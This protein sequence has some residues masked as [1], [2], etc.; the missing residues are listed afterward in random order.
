MDKSGFPFPTTFID[1]KFSMFAKLK[2]D[3]NDFKQVYVPGSKTI[4]RLERGFE[5]NDTSDSITDYYI[6]KIRFSCSFKGNK[7]PLEMYESFYTKDDIQISILKTLKTQKEKYEYLY[8]QGLKVCNQY[9]PYFAGTVYKYFNVTSIC[10]GSLGWF[11]R[12]MGA[13]CADNVKIFYGTDP[14]I[15]LK[16]CYDQLI[17]D[18]IPSS[19]KDFKLEYIPFEDVKTDNKYAMFMSSTPYYDL[20]LYLK[21]EDDI[22]KTQ[23]TTRYTTYNDWLKNFYKIYIENGLKMTTKYFCLYTSNYRDIKNKLIPLS[24]DTKYIMKQHADWKQ[25]PSIFLNGR[26]LLCWEKTCSVPLTISPPSSASL[27]P[28][29]STPSS[30]PSSIHLQ[31]PY[32]AIYDPSIY[33]KRFIFDKIFKAEPNV[34]T[35]IWS[36]PPGK[37]KSAN[38]DF[39]TF[40]KLSKIQCLP[41]GNEKEAWD[42]DVIADFYSEEARVKSIGYGETHSPFEFALSEKLRKERGI[43]HDMS[44]PYK[45]REEINEKIQEARLAY[46]TTSKSL[47]YAIVTNFLGKDVKPSILDIAAY[48][49][50]FFASAALGYDYSGID[51]NEYLTQG[52]VKL[53]SDMDSYL[54]TSETIKPKLNLFPL[55]S[56]E[57]F[58]N[59]KRYNIFSYSPPPFNLELYNATNEAQT[60]NMY[61][62]FENYILG[63]L[64]ESTIRA[65]HDFLSANGLF[66]F[67][68]LDRDPSKYKPKDSKAKDVEI[69]YVE[70]F[71]HLIVCLGFEYKSTISFSKSNVPWFIFKSVENP[72]QKTVHQ[73]L[74][75][76]EK[77]Y[78]FV[79]NSYRFRSFCAFKEIFFRKEIT[80]KDMIKIDSFD[81]KM[82]VKSIQTEILRHS[83]YNYI[84]LLLFESFEEKIPL[85][86]IRIYYSR[87]IAI[88]KS[89]GNLSFGDPVFPLLDL[90]V[91]K[92]VIN[93]ANR[94]FADNVIYANKN[95]KMD[96]IISVLNDTYYWFEANS[97]YRASQTQ[98]IA[99]L[100]NAASRF[101]S[102]FQTTTKQITADNVPSLTKQVS[103]DVETERY[104][105][106]FE[107]SGGHNF[108]RPI[109][110]SQILLKSTTFDEIIDLFAN[111]EN[112]NSISI[113]SKE[114]LPFFSLFED[115]KGSL[116][117]ALAISELVSGI[118][119]ANAID[120]EKITYATALKFQDLLKIAEKKGN[121]IFIIVGTNVWLDSED[122]KH[123]KSQNFDKI[124]DPT[125]NIYLNECK[126]YLIA[127]YDLD[128]TVFESTLNP[129]EKKGK[130]SKARAEI[131]SSFGIIL[132]TTNARKNK[133][134]K[135]YKSILKELGKLEFY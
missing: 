91:N 26:E 107:A 58:R 113:T 52:Y 106:L 68:A 57:N 9:N 46:I 2:K 133:L 41:A 73:S 122:Y 117:N 64:L 48:G 131:S 69:Y 32:R 111:F 27:A 112:T 43:K 126:K 59:S 86:K 30:T 50:R 67:T 89:L 33:K 49:E 79:Y 10:D 13:I 99:D 16:P 109:R 44:D 17:K 29:P 42:L 95:F 19:G 7:S 21:P 54:S 25:I 77:Y 116:G 22:N 14:N 76:L 114:K 97:F 65:K 93:I 4:L 45:F 80:Y 15:A 38:N 39:H 23:S 135:D 8:S 56:I 132:G 75:V 87:W 92:D 104:N 84:T 118:F 115:E 98:G 18:F 90:V 55:T 5:H 6:E 3:I 134:Q 121:E 40:F 74:T 12:G 88:V 127:T 110:R 37:I 34:K 100:T 51:P 105:V 60:F 35:T 63:F 31:F 129:Y 130:G 24:D 101:V 128:K 20:E 108:T 72:N 120:V 36:I 71:C 85:D 11:G 53:E 96:Y 81:Y 61:P 83:V 103:E 94:Q 47:Y 82:D 123:I 66:C 119:L 102:H 70:L 1:D 62:N 124:K 28:I 78:P 125:L